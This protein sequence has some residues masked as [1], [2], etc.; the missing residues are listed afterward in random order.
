MITLSIPEQLSNWAIG[1]DVVASYF[2]CLL[3]N[4]VVVVLVSCCLLLLLSYVIVRCHLSS[5]YVA[6]R[7]SGYIATIIIYA[8]LGGRLVVLFLLYCPKEELLVACCCLACRVVV[9]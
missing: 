9:Q 2:E 5:N 6:A 3:A 4:V 7:V 8:S 1:L